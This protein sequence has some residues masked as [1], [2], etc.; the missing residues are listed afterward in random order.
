MRAVETPGA[1]KWS[2]YVAAVDAGI[3]AARARGAMVFVVT[4]PYL[5]P[6]HEQ[7]QAFVARL[8]AERYAGD[9]KVRYVNLGKSLDLKDR[10]LC[11]DGAH[12]TSRGNEIVAAALLPEVLRAIDP[13]GPSA[14]TRD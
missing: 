10:A 8:V 2:D 5:G 14:T 9:A 6:V 7:Q 3:R 12:L 11:F 13:Q 4:E 1:A